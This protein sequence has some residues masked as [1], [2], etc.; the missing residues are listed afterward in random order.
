MQPIS[1]INV[2]HLNENKNN[3]EDSL[4]I[5]FKK[6]DIEPLENCNRQFQNA[7]QQNPFKLHSIAWACWVIAKLGGWRTFSKQDTSKSDV[8]M[9]QKGLDIYVERKAGWLMIKHLD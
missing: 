1:R 8:N 9:L 2:L 7:T 6:D 4:L 3:E 5:L